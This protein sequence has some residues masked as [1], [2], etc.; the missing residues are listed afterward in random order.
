MDLNA[1]IDQHL[2]FDH[3]KVSM[4]SDSD[5]SKGKLQFNSQGHSIVIESASPALIKF[6]INASGG[7]YRYG[8]TFKFKKKDM[9]FVPKCD[10]PQFGNYESCKHVSAIAIW[11]EKEYPDGITISESG[12]QPAASKEMANTKRVTTWQ[13]HL[14]PLELLRYLKYTDYYYRTKDEM[15]MPVEPTINEFTIEPPLWKSTQFV[16]SIK[17]L[18][19]NIFEFHCRCHHAKPCDHLTSILQT[20]HQDW[21]EKILLR[22][23]DFQEDKKRIL[24]EIGLP[25]E[26]SS[27]LDFKV[28]LQGHVKIMENEMIINSR[29]V[30]MIS[31]NLAYFKVEKK[32]D[33]KYDSTFR[34]A[35]H[36]NTSSNRSLIP[37]FWKIVEPQKGKQKMKY[38]IFEAKDIGPE[39]WKYLPDQLKNQYLNISVTQ[40]ALCR[41]Q[42]PISSD[43]SMNR[44][45]SE[46]LKLHTAAK[47]FWEYACEKNEVILINYPNFGNSKRKS[48][49]LKPYPGFAQIEIQYQRHEHYG[50]ITYSLKYDDHMVSGANL[51]ELI[52]GVY[53]DKEYVYMVTP[54]DQV[55]L[56]T[57]IPRNGQIVIQEALSNFEKDMLPGIASRYQVKEI[58]ATTIEFNENPKTLVK[59]RSLD[60][61][62]V[63]L[64]LSFKYQE[65]E[66]NWNDAL[67]HVY[68]TG[69]DGL[70]GKIH[71]NIDHE[72]EQFSIFQKH[73][74]A[75]Q[76]QSNREMFY[77]SF[78]DAQKNFLLLTAI[79]EW[80]VAG[81]E[82]HGQDTIK[83]LKLNPG[84]MNFQI[85]KGRDMGWFEMQINAS[86]GET[87]VDLVRLAK[88]LADKENYVLL[89]DGSLGYLPQSWIKKFE[90]LFRMSEKS[91]GDVLKVNPKHLMLLPS[92]ENIITDT[93]FLE[94]IRE[95]Q[96]QLENLDKLPA[97]APGKKIKADLRNY[98]LEGF[99]W[100]QHMS[101]TGFGACLADD[102]GLGK[103]L[104]TIC[105][106]DF[107]ISKNKQGRV[108]VVCPTSLLFN[109]ENELKKFAPHIKHHIH[110]GFQRE[111][112]TNSKTRVILTSYGTLR[113]D[114]EEFNKEE[115]LYA[116]L[117]ESQA[118]KNPNAQMSIAVQAL[119]TKNRL[120]LSGTPVQNNTFDLWSQFNFINPGLLGNKTSFQENFSNAIDKQRDA[121]TA[122]QL[123]NLVK[124]FILRRTKEQV[125]TDLPSRTESMLWCDMGKEQRKVYEE[126]REFYKIAIESSIQESGIENSSFLVLE[127]LLKLRQICDSPA[128][129][130]K[131][132]YNNIESSKLNELIREIEENTG[133][134]KVLVFSQFTE[135]LALIEHPLKTKKINYCYLDGSTSPKRR[136]EEVEKFQNNDE[137]RVFLISL[138]AGGVGLNLTQ[139]DYVYLV[140]PWWNPAAEQQAIDRT[141]RIGQDKPV[142]AYKMICKDSIEEKILKLQEHKKGIA[143][144]LIQAD[145]STFKKLSKADIV[146]LFSA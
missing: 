73:F 70:I 47:E 114:I 146:G 52:R 93:K 42:L 123:R 29:N 49:S 94:S 38:T 78:S 26:Y 10:C 55:S 102:M 74:P 86:F 72:K 87:K 17:Y 48:E 14:K 50:E 115:W 101:Y 108:L 35:I 6:S 63:L 80:I 83:G 69:E 124:P 82:I 20:Q 90:L 144:D 54:E 30:N 98:Q 51:K 105:F 36:A 60:E 31:R 134:H 107:L 92:D 106:I 121:S 125:A 67:P 24:S 21:I 46:F 64:Q 133:A 11:F 53:Q 81:F 7:Q 85:T 110:H 111:M 1:T 99:Y 5:K 129:L 56:S 88:A 75:F 116:I 137:I 127:G 118:I 130:K 12:F 96:S 32:S 40:D 100:L 131:V 16:T 103:T 68:I 34:A 13:E 132:K 4:E 71:R 142:F 79:H 27:Q 128:L 95:K 117:D 112:K 65:T 136:K 59:L 57:Y 120:I 45:T 138:K 37:F 139:A 3:Y 25:E 104:Q 119:R 39:F 76:K 77:V 18:G 84:K 122:E 109:W 33:F 58:Q 89:D 66:I 44:Y 15:I 22:A 9:I 28:N 143:G 113:N 135:M 97:K 41:M 140:D 126:L 19:E 62:M 43:Q 141:H 8:I 61:R 145:S 23:Q 2:L 91:K